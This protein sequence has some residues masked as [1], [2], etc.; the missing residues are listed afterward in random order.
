MAHPRRLAA[1]MFTD[2]VGFTASAQADEAGA[3]RRLEEQ[4]E[5]LRPLLSSH[6]GREVKSTG[7]GFLVEFES[8]LRATECAIAIQRLLH[9]RN[10]ARGVPP[11]ELRIGVHLGDVEP[12]GGDIF[13]D[14]VNIAARVAPCALP[15][16][17]CL[18][19]PVVDQVRNKIPN[20]LERLESRELKNVRFPVSLYRVLFP[21][22]GAGSAPFLPDRVERPRIVILPLLNL[23]PD[24][25]DAYLADGIT[26]EL[27]TAVARL[28][29]LS[30]IS[31][32]SAMKYRGAAKTVREIGA[33]LGVAVALEGSLRKSGTTV[34]VTAQLIDVASDRHLWSQSYDR[35]LK[36]IF[37]IESELSTQVASALEVQL[38]AGGGRALFG[39][40][41]DSTEAHT[42]YLR[43]RYFWNR[44]AQEWLRTAIVEFERTIAAD[45]NYAP[46]YAGLADVYLM[47]GRRGEAPLADVYPKAVANAQ[48]ALALDPGL[49]EPHAALGA[50]RQEYEWNWDESEREFRRAVELG[51]SY[52]LGWTWYALF[53]GHVGRFDEAIRHARRAQ[54]LDPVSARAHAGA[55]EEYLFAR[56]YDYAIE[57]GVR[58]LEV[59]PAF[60]LAEASIAVALVEQGKYDEALGRFDRAIERVGAQ[61]LLGR[62][63]HA[64]AKA[65]RKDEARATIDALKRQTTLSP[66]ASPFLSPAPYASLDIALIYLG[67]QEVE[68]ALEWLER[69]QEQHVPEVVHYKCEPIFDGVQGEPRFQ[70]LIRS[71]GLGP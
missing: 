68:P 30:V 1:I 45:A 8:A 25:A 53:L 18:T 51:P 66:S 2:V 46:A 24:P 12:R 19:E 49:A 61:A 71:M 29:G 7:D 35:E 21:W 62:R 40:S 6:Q 52:S 36:D 50:I 41:T 38:G 27:T 65:G 9:E 26:E 13:G 3:L 64:L 5:L 54:A 48:R 63:G 69:A 4:E 42:F 31:R 59:D 20:S 43:G 15:G 58:A 22:D 37:A 39:R 32:T 57:A 16:G 60:G 56:Q 70:A 23:S 28:P 10:T 11:L 44:A 17:I 33:E 47:L 34:R 55:A 14:A 67:L